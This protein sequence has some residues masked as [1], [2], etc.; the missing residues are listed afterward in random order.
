M[1]PT[2]SPSSPSK[3]CSTLSSWSLSENTSMYCVL[4]IVHLCPGAQGS[5]HVKHN[6]LLMRSFCVSSFSFS[7][8]CVVLCGRDLVSCPLCG[9]GVYAGNGALVLGM[10]PCNSLVHTTT[11]CSVEGLR[12]FTSPCRGSRKHSMKVYTLLAL[13]RS[14]TITN[15]C[16]KLEK[17]CSR[18]PV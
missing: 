2:L 4:P 15:T 10:A 13:D 7:L 16:R 17:Y 11:S 18:L 1:S 14:G 9:K 5:L 3:S 6:F 12:D 8:P